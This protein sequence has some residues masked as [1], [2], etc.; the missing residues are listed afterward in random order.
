MKNSVYTSGIEIPWNL[1]QSKQRLTVDVYKIIKTITGT[2]NKVELSNNCNN[3]KLFNTNKQLRIELEYKWIFEN[4][5]NEMIQYNQSIKQLRESS[6][7]NSKSIPDFLKNVKILK[8]FQTDLANLLLNNP[9]KIDS[10][11]PV[12]L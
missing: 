8:Q 5:I 11:L 2:F 3:S 12:E 4:E 6:K 7:Y 1:E 9:A 10:N